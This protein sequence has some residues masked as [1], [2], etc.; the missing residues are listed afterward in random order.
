M[1]AMPPC[2]PKIRRS[3]L[4]RPPSPGSTPLLQRCV[5]SGRSGIQAIFGSR[6]LFWPPAPTQSSRRRRSRNSLITC[7]PA[8]RSRS[9]LETRFCRS[10]IAIA[11]SSGRRSTRLCRDSAVQIGSMFGIQDVA[12]SLG[13][14]FCS[15]HARRTGHGLYRWPQYATRLAW[16]RC[17]SP[18]HRRGCL[19]H[20]VAASVGLSALLAARRAFTLVNTR[21]P[22][23]S[24]LRASDAALRAT[25]R[26]GR[27][28]RG[29]RNDTLSVLA[30]R[31]YQ[32]AEP[33]GRALLSCVPAAIR[34]HQRPTNHSHSCCWACCSI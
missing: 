4:R 34:P 6:C 25:S 27:I 5:A 16:R 26:R 32:C 31:P 8:R 30:R 22:P 21:A 24:A 20:I 1:R 15:T 33:E 23:I 17:R 11:N 3:A 9:R 12:C 2:S 10:R 13:R 19:V 7:V 29:D 14:G 28:V 18:R